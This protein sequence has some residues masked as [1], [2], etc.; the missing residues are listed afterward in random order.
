VL[1]TEWGIERFRAAV[2][3]R[4]G[5]TLAR[6]GQDETVAYGGDHI[7]IHEQRQPGRC[8]AGLLVPVGRVTGT[9]LRELARLGDVYG[10]GE[11]RLTPDQNVIIPHVPRASVPAL[12]RERL[13]EVFSP[14]PSEVLRGLVACTGIDYCHFSLIDTKAE[15]LKLARQLEDRLLVDRALRIYMSGCPNACG[16]H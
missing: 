14:F 2:E 11:V 4:L 7:G 16:Q 8:Y 3:E 6:A 9:Q 1:L 15:A 13:L 10:A 5:E 12:L